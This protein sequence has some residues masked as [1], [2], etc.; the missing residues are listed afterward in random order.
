MRAK[1]PRTRCSFPSPASSRSWARMAKRSLCEESPSSAASRDAV[2]SISRTFGF[3]LATTTRAALGLPMFRAVR[4]IG[5]RNAFRYT[6]VCTTVRAV[7]CHIVPS[8]HTNVTAKNRAAVVP[9][10]SVPVFRKFVPHV[11]TRLVVPTV[12]IANVQR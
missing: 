8:T 4:K 7:S 1:P 5:R 11:N 9:V 6:Y 12:V 10:A 3:L 2:R